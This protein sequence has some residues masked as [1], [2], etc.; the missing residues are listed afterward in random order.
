[1]V[2]LQLCRPSFDEQPSSSFIPNSFWEAQI[3]N[4]HLEF[5]KILI[6]S[7]PCPWFWLPYHGDSNEGYVQRVFTKPNKLDYYTFGRGQQ[8]IFVDTEIAIEFEYET[9]IASSSLS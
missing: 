8:A 9:N 3:T 4:L 5:L 6:V 1:M 7:D 2:E